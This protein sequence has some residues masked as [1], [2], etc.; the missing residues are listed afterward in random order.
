MRLED[1]LD[2][3]VCG[4]LYTHDLWGRLFVA[5]RVRGAVCDIQTRRFYPSPWWP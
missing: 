5:D 3:R 1:Y 2:R 4:L